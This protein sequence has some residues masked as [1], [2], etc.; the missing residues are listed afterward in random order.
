MT[1]HALLILTV[2][3]FA[4]SQ[5]KG[6]DNPKIKDKKVS[7]DSLVDIL[8][9]KYPDIPRTRKNKS[10]STA[11]QLVSRHFYPSLDSLTFE[12]R[13]YR[14][15]GGAWEHQFIYIY[16]N[17]TQFIL[18]LIDNYY[19]WRASSDSK[20][21]IDSLKSKFCLKDEINNALRQI[22]IKDQHLG[23]GFNCCKEKFVDII[24]DLMGYR[25]VYNIDIPKMK[26]FSNG[27]AQDSFLY[28]S[29]CKT[30]FLDNLKTIENEVNNP[31]KDRKIY[32]NLWTTYIVDFKRQSIDLTVLNF[33]CNAQIIF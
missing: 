18:P 8:I 15:C 29:N 31:K 13:Q 9:K 16:N 10:P 32:S 33:E 19:Y 7:L 26:L 23:L 21:N 22:N 20:I 11:H 24:M 12:L 28:N 6:T 1:K 4:C 14:D 25:P 27:I 30:K 5:D 2:F 17:S 3:F